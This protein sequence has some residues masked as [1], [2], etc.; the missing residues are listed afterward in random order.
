MIDNHFKTYEDETEF[1]KWIDSFS[2]KAKTIKKILNDFRTGNLVDKKDLESKSDYENRMKA[3]KL[4]KEEANANIRD[5]EWKHIETFGKTPSPQAK[6]AIHQGVKNEKRNL[7]ELEIDELIK[8]GII[9]QVYDGW[10]CDCK[11]CPF[12]M[13]MTDRISALHEIARHLS[14]VHG[15]VILQK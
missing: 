1:Q 14:A 2:E 11:I 4:K 8:F 6:E 10:K 5:Y 9:Q 12:N 3:A 7:T 15:K 13:I